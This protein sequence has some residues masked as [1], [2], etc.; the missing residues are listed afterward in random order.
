M[1]RQ[2]FLKWIKVATKKS[3]YK[4]MILF[5]S[6]FTLFIIS[7]SSFLLIS[8][9]NAALTNEAKVSN[10]RLLMQV[11]I[12]SDTLL[13]ESINSLISEKFLDLYRD[14]NVL[15]F[16]SIN[17]SDN[18][19]V[20]LRIYDDLSIIATSSSIIDSIYVYRNFDKTLVSSREGICTFI[21]D[22]ADAERLSINFKP[23]EE[24]LPYQQPC[25]KWISPL[26]NIDFMQDQP[27][28]TFIQSIPLIAQENN[29]AGF[30]VVNINE[31]RFY[32][33]INHVSDA[34][35]N[36]FMI[37]DT[38]GR[39]F[40]Q[41]RRNEVFNTADI[42]GYLKETLD[43]N[44]GFM[45][46]PINEKFYGISWTTSVLNNWKYISITPVDI[47]NKELFIAKQF[48]VIL[49]VFT[50]LFTLLGLRFI[51]SRL[52]KPIRVLFKSTV[53]KFDVQSGNDNELMVI[54]K[55]I[56]NLSSRVEEMSNTISENQGIIRHRTVMDI[57]NGSIS[58]QE[59][60]IERLNTVDVYMSNS[61]FCIMITD[62]DKRSFNLL[63]P[64]QK[65]YVIYKIIEMIDNSLNE[66]CTCISISP[67]TKFVAT[68]MNFE[69]W[70]CI[71][72]RIPSIIQ[73]I[74]SYTGVDCNM[75]LSGNTDS[76]LNLSS[77]Y[78][79]TQSILKYEFIYNYGNVFI[80]DAMVQL[81]KNDRLFDPS[82]LDD[83]T[84]LLK[85]CRISVVKEEVKKLFNIL[86]TGNY[87][88]EHVQNTLVQFIGMFCKVIKEQNIDS[89]FDK[90]SI[91]SRFNRIS[92]LDECHQWLLELT[93]IYE[94]DINNRNSSIN[95]DF[96]DKITVYI[97]ENIES[98]LSLSS[99]AEAFKISPN[100]LSKIFKEGSGTNFSDFVVQKKI[101]KA[102]ELLLADKKITVSDIAKKLGYYS[103]TYF[104]S[105]F[106]EN[107]GITPSMLRKSKLH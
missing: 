72:A 49:I 47:I 23:I 39:I 45:V 1:L 69:D 40:S 57:I 107:Y 78:E 53:E 15:D 55:V 36:E 104:I 7:F 103:T 86:K 14:K 18:Y 51:T 83:I 2:H 33:S 26:E 10:S 5:Y 60:L 93:D 98:Q 92:S 54:D 73:A 46:T 43:I 41:S 80:Y 58:E 88:Y 65:E 85:S 8:H 34:N 101:E 70:E 99:V 66:I 42:N 95:T 37:M 106:K 22:S 16:F 67:N 27:I 94:T 90:K 44:D 91:F 20:L 102:K 35:M 24:L 97:C 74:R 6:A 13:R 21:A 56:K 61:L 63:T 4:K 12:Y 59:E 17:Q 52:Y 71:K 3:H 28:I 29:V 64:K 9:F 96:I 75:A 50:S 31:R 105:L 68:I 89:G 32:Q 84:I 48:A 30:V 11:K 38:E 62:M 19:G 81:E 79:C 87:T 82:Q 25:S 77:F 76:M 100:Y